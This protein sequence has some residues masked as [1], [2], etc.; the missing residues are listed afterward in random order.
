ME[1][2]SSKK[3]LQAEN[4]LKFSK[5]LDLLKKHF[6]YNGAWGVLLG[7]FFYFCCSFIPYENFKKGVRIDN[8]QLAYDEIMKVIEPF[9][10]KYNAGLSINDPNKFSPY[11][12][13]SQEL[14]DLKNQ[15][16]YFIYSNHNLVN[17]ELV[18]KPGQEQAVIEGKNLINELMG[19]VSTNINDAYSQ[20]CMLNY[21]N[22]IVAT[23]TIASIGGPL[24]A[25]SVACYPYL[26]AKYKYNKLKNKEEVLEQ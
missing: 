16:N 7:T 5:K 10:E 22:E 17:G 6:P 26:K 9:N 21:G 1:K 25:I 3:P 4:S 20:L 15:I 24:I 14:S 8:P 18:I 12:P 2:I 19:N 11:I 23:Q 13:Y